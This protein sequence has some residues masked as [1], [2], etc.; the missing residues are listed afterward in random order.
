[1]STE[2]KA[3]IMVMVLRGVVKASVGQVVGNVV[4]ATIPPGQSKAGQFSAKLG[5]M[6]LG[7]MV[8]EMAWEHV[9]KSI[10]NAYTA[11]EEAQKEQE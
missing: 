2:T 6:I 4:E 3:K 8:G 1:M 9:A 5:G 11:Y 10:A 7:N